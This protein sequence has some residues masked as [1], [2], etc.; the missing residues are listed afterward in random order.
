MELD[1]LKNTWDDINN[2]A[3][4]QENLNPKMINQMTQIKFKARLNKVAYP[5]IVGTILAF[6]LA[7]N[8]GLNLDKLNT[9]FLQS[10]GIMCILILVIQPA[11]SLGILWQLNMIGDV[12]KSYAE[13]LKKFAIQK[14]RFFKFQKISLVSSYILLGFLMILIPKFLGKDV[15]DNK[16]I[17]SFTIFFGYIFLYVF[18]RWVLKSY[19]KAL[20][21]A[22][23]L[24][25]EL[26]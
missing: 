23:E 2:Q 25:K 10:L 18:S 9:P 22:E 4:K 16:Y 3:R 5:E 8:I 21:Q 13:T 7:A 26:E 14:L 20:Q 24:L 17:W 15:N 6:I 19:G 1:D 12:N 11:I